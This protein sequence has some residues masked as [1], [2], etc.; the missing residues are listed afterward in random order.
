MRKTE[1]LTAIIACYR[2]GQAIPVMYER[3]KKTFKK[4]GV[5]YEI[6]FVNDGSPDDSKL[7]LDKITKKDGNV[8]AITHSRNFGS[9]M[10]FSSGMN[11]ATGDAVILLDGDLQDPPEI[12]SDFYKKWK[13]GFDVVYGI[14]VKREASNF[15]QVA[16]KMFYRL[17][18]KLSYI[19]VPL[20]AGDFSLMDKKVVRAINTLPEKDRFLRGLRAW[21][22]FKQT[23]IPYIR[24]ERLFGKTTNSLH[25]N[26]GWARKGIFSFSYVPLELITYISLAVALLSMVGIVI[27]IILKIFFPDTP[28]GV[29]ITLVTI[30]F[31]GSMQLLFISVIGEYVGKI[32][33]EVKNRPMY[34]VKDIVNKPKK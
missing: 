8:V 21:V 7:V 31:L 30:L 20:D 28:R 10:A 9:Q 4:I 14:R 19:H 34:I 33:E 24:P 15:M 22:G 11:I 2:D 17:F 1:T 25:K 5:G 26:F 3:L 32:F 16:Y 27:E 29:P 12:I 18:Q 23:G 6:I 13:E